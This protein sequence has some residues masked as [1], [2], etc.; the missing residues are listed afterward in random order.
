MGEHAGEESEEERRNR[1][2]RRREERRDTAD[3]V[4]DTCEFIDSVRGC[5][6]GCSRLGRGRGGSD[7]CSC[8]GPC[9]FPLLRVSPLLL[10]AA[11]MVPARGASG[12]V[13]AALLGYQRWLSRFTPVCPSTPS[14]SAYALGAVAR[15][16]ARRG[17]RLA[18]ARVRGCSS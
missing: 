10:V 11:A 8:D 14:C 12:L 18:A 3:A 15:H 17:L 1:R 4:G 9:D 16:G 7:G 2:R 13:R 5:G 6:T